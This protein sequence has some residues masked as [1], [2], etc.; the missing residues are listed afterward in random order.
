MI[1]LFYLDNYSVSGDK[2]LNTYEILHG[3][4]KFHEISTT[5]IWL[6]SGCKEIRL[7]FFLSL[8]VIFYQII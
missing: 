5:P 1:N 3:L 7:L 4:Q 2:G 8:F 6:N